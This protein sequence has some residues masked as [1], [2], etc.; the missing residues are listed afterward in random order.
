MRAF[1]VFGCVLSAG[2]AGLPAT[3]QVQTDTVSG[4]VVAYPAV[5]T[6]AGSGS[7][8]LRGEFLVDNGSVPGG[9][10]SVSGWEQ[11]YPFTQFQALTIG[12]AAGWSVTTIGIDGC[13]WDDP[14]GDHRHRAA[15]HQR[16][17]G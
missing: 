3:A 6:P 12:D 17:A 8:T 7:A 15:G 4:Q 14:D 13:F 9:G 1:S 2:V 16:R 11:E 5:V 10:W